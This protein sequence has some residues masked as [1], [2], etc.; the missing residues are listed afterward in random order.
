MKSVFLTFCLAVAC[1]AQV[2][3]DA[4]HNVVTKRASAKASISAQDIAKW[5]LAH[6][7]TLGATMIAGQEATVSEHF[8]G[9]GPAH[10]EIQVGGGKFYMTIGTGTLPSGVQFDEFSVKRSY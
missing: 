4:P 8:I 7:V 1:A 6:P 5:Y 9:G 2:L 10:Y 3:P